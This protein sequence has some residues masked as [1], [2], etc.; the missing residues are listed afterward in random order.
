MDKQ[1]STSKTVKLG[2]P[3]YEEQLLKWYQEA[4]SDCSDLENCDF[5]ETEAILSEHETDSEIEGECWIF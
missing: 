4:D 5:D 2:D 3:G 1:P